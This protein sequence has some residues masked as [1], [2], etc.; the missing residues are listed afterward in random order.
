MK[1]Y[2]TA[3]CAARLKA[4]LEA[5]LTERKARLTRRNDESRVLLL[6]LHA[7]C[8]YNKPPQPAMSVS[9]VYGRA[10]A[11]DQGAVKLSVAHS[12]FRP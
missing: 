12:Q 3:E 7:L 9:V 8:I 11:P 1:K 2:S 10:Q 6:P 5:V 4:L